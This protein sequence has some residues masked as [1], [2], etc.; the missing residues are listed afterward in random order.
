M[1]SYKKVNA[2]RAAKKIDSQTL[3]LA[4]WGYI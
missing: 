3:I 1:K 4:L 2:T